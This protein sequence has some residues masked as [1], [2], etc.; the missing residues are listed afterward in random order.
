LSFCVCDSVP[1]EFGIAWEQA[2]AISD[3][4]SMSGQTCQFC[5]LSIGRDFAKRYYRN[6][7]PN[8]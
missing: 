6:C 4:A 1:G 3:V 7:A 8:L 5:D 2:E